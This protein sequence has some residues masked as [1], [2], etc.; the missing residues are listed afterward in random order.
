M[1]YAA[2]FPCTRLEPA[3]GLFEIAFQVIDPIEK[4]NRYGWSS[5]G[6]M[7]HGRQ[8]PLQALRQDSRG[9]CGR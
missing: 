9:C 1:K 8:P 3:A 7:R 6:K 5:D 4:F 2:L